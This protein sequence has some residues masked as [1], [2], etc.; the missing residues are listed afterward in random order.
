MPI[1]IHGKTYW[2]VAER[3]GLAHADKDDPLQSVITEPVR[4]F[5]DGGV[6]FRAVVTF[7]SGRTFTGH[8]YESPASKGIAGQSPWEVAETSAV[9]R[10]LGLAGYGSDD[11]V[12]SAEEVRRA[13]PP[14]TPAPRPAQ[15]AAPPP[16][17]PPPAAGIPT[18]PGDLLA[19]VNGR[20]EAPYDNLPH[21]LQV[22][23]KEY[24][25]PRWQW[26]QPRDLDGW[27]DAYR[28]AIQ[29]AQRKTATPASSAVVVP[30]YEG[31]G[32]PADE[33]AF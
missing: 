15:P 24:N 21:L 16:P 13:S 26:P 4:V 28:R 11:S 30:D 2:P 22:L 3:L 18:K 6:T 17:S 7:Q 33:A 23:R 14:A 1:A 5:D 8:A 12:A 29:H 25:D 9:G 27:R 10:A 31:S 32:Q 20:V 19:V